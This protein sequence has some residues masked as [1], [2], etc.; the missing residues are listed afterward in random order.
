MN[1]CGAQFFRHSGPELQDVWVVDCMT[2][3]WYA[4]DHVPYCTSLT[5][6]RGS[7]LCTWSQ[8]SYRSTTQRMDRVI[9]CTLRCRGSSTPFEPSLAAFL[10]TCE[11]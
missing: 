2:C 9:L 5:R 4:T 1:G 7:R 10:E 3:A 8:G 11:Y 6:R